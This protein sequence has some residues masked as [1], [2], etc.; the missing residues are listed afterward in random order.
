MKK[1]S[2]DNKVDDKCE[3][4]SDDEDTECIENVGTD[5]LFGITEAPKSIP[6]NESGKLKIIME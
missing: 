2:Q 1:K 4:D 3:N 5:D 6:G